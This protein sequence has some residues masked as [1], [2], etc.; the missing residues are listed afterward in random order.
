MPAFQ[1]AQINVARLVAPLDHPQLADFVADLAD[2]SEGCVWRL[3]SE[4]RD[5]TERAF[6]LSQLFAAPTAVLA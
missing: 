5:A 3:Q 6:W 2:R 1:L 4:N